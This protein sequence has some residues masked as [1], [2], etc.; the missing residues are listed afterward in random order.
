MHLNRVIVSSFT[1]LNNPNS[2]IAR[3]RN[4]S[5]L[6]AI[7]AGLVFGND[8]PLWIDDVAIDVALAGAAALT[9]KDRLEVK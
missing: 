4:D 1:V 2:H 6:A 9:T 8:P 5:K 7:F 3:S